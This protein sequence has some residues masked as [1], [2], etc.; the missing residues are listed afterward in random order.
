MGRILFGTLTLIVILLIVSQS[1]AGAD[2]QKQIDKH[3]PGFFILQNNEF[4]K[5]M[6]KFIKSENPGFITGRFNGDDHTD[7]AA[8]IRGKNKRRY[9]AGVHSYDFYDGKVIVCHGLK[10]TDY[11]CQIIS[12]SNT[13]LPAQS[14][15]KTMKPQKTGCYN[16]SGKKDY[17]DVK[18]DT[19]GLYYYESGGSHY[20]YQEDGTYKNCVTSD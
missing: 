5:D 10:S 4:S 16:N 18:K 12:E 15:L 11:K 6:M 17:I 20:I 9:D 2:F 8:M 19:I 13:I 14:F 1:M 7:F 3:Y